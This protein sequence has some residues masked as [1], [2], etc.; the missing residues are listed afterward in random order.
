MSDLEGVGLVFNET[1]SGWIGKGETDFSSGVRKGKREKTSISFTVSIQIE[2]LAQFLDISHHT[3]SLTGTVTCATFGADI[4]IQDGRFGLFTMDP[5]TGHRQMTYTFRFTAGDGQ[6]YFLRGLKVLK[7]DPGF[8]LLDDMTTLYTFIH[9]GPD[10]SSQVY[11]AGIMRF[12]LT[13]TMDLMKSIDVINAKNFWQ[14]HQA[15]IAFISFVF[16]QTRS[17][18]LRKIN[19]LYDTSY[20]N[21]VLCGRVQGPGGAE[22]DFFLVSGVHD[23]D[24][25]WGDGE[26]FSDVLLVLG[27]EASGYGRYC[28]SERTLPDLSLDVQKGKYRYQGT[29]HEIT[30]G[31]ATSF[32][33]MRKPALNLAPVN[34]YFEIDFQ[35]REYAT[36][37]LPFLTAENILADLATA[38]K[39]ALEKFLPSERLLGIAITPHTVVV[40]SGR[41]SLNKG[42]ETAEYTILPGATFGEAE[43]STLR[44]VKAPVMLYNYI[45]GVQPQATR[46]RVQIMADTMRST[47]QYWIK[48]QVEALMGDAV[49]HLASKEILLEGGRI[50]V[51]ELSGSLAAPTGRPKLFESLGPP[52]LEVNNDHFP[53]A[54]FQRRIIKVRDPGGD[55]CLALEEHMNPLRLQAL[56]SGRR[57]R[58]AAV[59]D[60][61]KFKALDKVLEQTGFHDHIKAAWTASKKTKQ[62]FLYCCQTQLHVCL[63]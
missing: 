11:G 54:I 48:D 43:R 7:D 30:S 58:V 63:Q 24:F 14:T 29:L 51:G 3:A 31:Y 40:R 62:D 37:P 4:P 45:C 15:K 49:S 17:L 25:P 26:I 46:A 32:S 8:D 41:L 20:E 18:Y 39:K 52:L 9:A 38:L 50:M 1:M 12:K 13:D 6:V 27:D 59:K 16:D 56:N 19:P 44:N 35:A 36:T 22:K 47:P 23:K 53:T 57:C 2:N 21:L 55:Q 42:A 28:I 10:E 33:A 5:D 61:D 34:V 60:E